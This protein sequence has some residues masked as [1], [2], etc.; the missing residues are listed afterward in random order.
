MLRTGDDL[1][2]QGLAHVTEIIAVPGDAHDQA[3]VLFR[4]FLRGPQGLGIDDAWG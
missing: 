2:L 4:A 1:I 3:A